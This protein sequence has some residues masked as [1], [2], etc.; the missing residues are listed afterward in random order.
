MFVSFYFVA[1]LQARSTSSLVRS[2]AGKIS[3]VFFLRSS[4]CV[5]VFVFLGLMR[6][7]RYFLRTRKRLSTGPA[8]RRLVAPYISCDAKKHVLTVCPQ[9]VGYPSGSPDFPIQFRTSVSISIFPNFPDSFHLRWTTTIIT[10]ITAIITAIII[11]Q[12]FSPAT[13]SLCT[14]PSLSLPVSPKSALTPLSNL[15]SGSSLTSFLRST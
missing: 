11:A 7:V 1:A 4:L 15:Y 12:R 10:I 13:L 14:T 8:G 3:V 5:K 2:R 9:Q 6:F